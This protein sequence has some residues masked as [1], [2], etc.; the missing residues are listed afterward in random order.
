MGAL[1]EGFDET[2]LAYRKILAAQAA[3]R[4]RSVPHGGRRPGRRRHASTRRRD[5][6]A[7]GFVAGSWQAEDVRAG[8]NSTNG[9]APARIRFAKDGIFFV[10]GGT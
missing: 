10:P 9:A 6:R 1:L 8:R 5:L 7:G 4:M 3:R 2:P